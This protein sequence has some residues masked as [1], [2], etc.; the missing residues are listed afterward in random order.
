[1][2]GGLNFEDEKRVD[3]E[4]RRNVIVIFTLGGSGAPRISEGGREKEL[5]LK[6]GATTGER[7]ALN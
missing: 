7:R 2:P 6:G 3:I 4:G 5:I 1:M